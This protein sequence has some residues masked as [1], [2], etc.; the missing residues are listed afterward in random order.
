[1]LGRLFLSPGSAR[2]LRTWPTRQRDLPQLSAQPTCLE[3][4]PS[5][6][7]CSYALRPQLKESATASLEQ[8]DLAT[9]RQ[10]ELLALDFAAISR[11]ESGPPSLLPH[12]GVAG[13]GAH[14]LAAFW[15]AK[16]GP[17]FK[18]AM[19]PQTAGPADLLKLSFT[20]VRAM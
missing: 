15:P 14:F 17:L 12:S 18:V 20:P 3:R 1:V 2:E 7:P 9:L 5:H 10:V 4:S 6:C 11:L 19:R 16:P 13:W 8:G